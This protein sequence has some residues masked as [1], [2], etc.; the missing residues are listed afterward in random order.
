[1]QEV[2]QVV[3]IAEGTVKKRVEEF[4]GTG[5]GGMTIGDFRTVWLEEEGEPPAFRKGREKERREKE[6]REKREREMS[7]EGVEE[8][9]DGGEEGSGSGSGGGK[10]KRKEKEN[11][12][13]KRRKKGESS[14]DEVDTEDREKE[15]GQGLG[16]KMGVEMDIDINVEDAGHRLPIDPRLLN[17]GILAGVGIDGGGEVPLFLPDDSSRRE[18]DL[19]LISNLNSNPD[20][21]LKEGDVDA[22]SDLKERTK[23]RGEEIEDEALEKEVIEYLHNEQ[24]S[25]IV[26]ALD[27]VD[28]R[29][30]EG[31]RMFKK[32][33]KMNQ[34]ATVESEEATEGGS[35]VDSGKTK[36]DEGGQESRRENRDG[37]EGG[38]R[39]SRKDDK[40]EGEEGEEDDDDDDE[41]EGLDENELDQFIL[42]EEE[43]RIK[44]RVW[45]EINRDYLE[46]IASEFIFLVFRYY[47]RFVDCI[48]VLFFVLEFWSSIVLTSFILYWWIMDIYSLI[49]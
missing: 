37:G 9:V 6:E 48:L 4:R 46:A 19:S 34:R 44:E 33:D 49:R 7:G 31:M 30:R 27:E 16:M 23:E 36:G 25:R 15:G 14:G 1:M 22:I 35:R 18:V 20:S 39:E 29:R 43:V 28:E 12:K 26:E 38:E 13:R 5:S 32:K 8:G 40:M 11:G 3:K 47:C 42:S 10:R 41:L 24:G 17:E 45:V 2:V 21:V